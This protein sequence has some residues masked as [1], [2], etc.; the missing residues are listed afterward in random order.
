MN[1]LVVTIG[2][3]AIAGACFWIAYFAPSPAHAAE[4]RDVSA[5]TVFAEIKASGGVVVDT[6]N[7]DGVYGDTLVFYVIDGNL[8]MIGLK[9]ECFQAGPTLMDEIRKKDTGQPA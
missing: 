4:C 3:L 8:W 1:K 9:G 6:V 7:Y 5:E 2:A